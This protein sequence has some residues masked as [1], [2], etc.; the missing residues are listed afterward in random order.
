M[1]E[2]DPRVRRHSRCA[3]ASGTRSSRRRWP[4][5][6]RCSAASTRATSTSATSGAPTPACSP[7]CTRS[8]RW[9]RPHEGTTLSSLLAPFD[10]Y[11]ASGEI[12]TEVADQAAVT[13]GASAPTF[14]ARGVTDIDEL[15][16]LTVNGDDLVVQRPAQQHRAAAA[17]ERRGRRRGRRWPLLRD[18]VL[19]HDADGSLTMTDLPDV[20]HPSASPPTCGTS[21][22]ARARSTRPSRPTRPRGAIGVHAAAARPSRCATASPSCCSTR[23]TPG[24]SGIGAPVAGLT[25]CSSSG[26]PSRTTTGASSTASQPWSGQAT[27]GAA[28]RAVVRRAPGRPVAR[29]STR[30]ARPTG[31]LLA[32]HFD[33]E[34]IPLLVKLLAAA[35]PLS[36]QVHPPKAVAAAGWRAQQRARA[37]SRSTATRSRRP[38]CWSPSS[39]LRGVRRLAR[40]ASRRRRSCS[41]PRTERADGGRRPARRRSRRRPSAC[42]CAPPRLTGVAGAG[43]GRPRRRAA[44]RRGRRLPRRSPRCT[45]TT[46]VRC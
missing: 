13:A 14:V 18:E 9:A 44:R 24:P 22:P 32:D 41:P 30:P 1:P 10:R 25:A 23:R 19:A 16:G 38:R 34:A 40:P 39:R 36:V 5:P 26:G 15:D 3:R 2:V 8:P 46:P 33:I 27:A 21:S 43:G 31:E 6:A 35:R 42:C 29:W 28:G 20:R 4:R 12:N 11:V 45:P 37:P 17:A 7:R